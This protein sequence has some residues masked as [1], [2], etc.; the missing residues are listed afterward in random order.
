MGFA[1]DP[2]STRV[3]IV[4]FPARRPQKRDMTHPNLVLLFRPASAQSGVVPS[5]DP[6]H[7]DV[8]R[9]IQPL[10]VSILKLHQ[11][12]QWVEADTALMAAL[13]GK[14]TVSGCRRARAQLRRKIP[15]GG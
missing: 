11:C 2:A 15:E 3:A 4:L 1:P 5:N 12:L 8:T 9:P 6:N 7:C 13:G 14:P 10:W